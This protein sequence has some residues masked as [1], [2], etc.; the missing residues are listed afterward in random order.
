MRLAHRSV[1]PTPILLLTSV[2]RIAVLLGIGWLIAQW[3]PIALAGFALSFVAA[4]FVAI[5]MAR[6]S[7]ETEV[8]RCN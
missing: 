7:A 2:L 3:S 1:R 6:R 5:T 8:P 4:R